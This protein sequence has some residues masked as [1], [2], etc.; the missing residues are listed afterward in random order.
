MKTANR[1]AAFLLLGSALA[2]TPKVSAQQLETDTNEEAPLI[3]SVPNTNNGLLTPYHPPEEIDLVD[4]TVKDVK[5]SYYPNPGSGFINIENAPEKDVVVKVYNLAGQ[6]RASFTIS[7][8]NNKIDVRH[9]KNGI[10]LL[11]S[12]LGTFKYIKA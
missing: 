11:Q 5:I 2:Y 6:V 12:E 3:L 1:I 4:N 8:E 9:L 7:E 10:Y